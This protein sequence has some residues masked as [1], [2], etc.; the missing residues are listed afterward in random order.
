MKTETLTTTFMSTAQCGL[1]FPEEISVGGRIA[2][3]EIVEVK[4]GDTTYKV[5]R[6][7]GTYWREWDEERDGEK[8]KKGR[9]RPKKGS[10]DNVKS[11]KWVIDLRV[12]TTFERDRDTLSL[13]VSVDGKDEFPKYCS[14][15]TFWIALYRVAIELSKD[16][17]AELTYNLGRRY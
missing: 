4:D 16:A 12:P 1:N 15:M 14:A 2:K 3:L 17:D 10:T 13:H 8:P 9:G 11:C 5:A 7:E 6:Y